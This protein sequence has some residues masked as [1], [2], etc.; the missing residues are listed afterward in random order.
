MRHA[1]YLVFR[2]CGAPAAA[3]HTARPRARDADP[4]SLLDSLLPPTR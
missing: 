1:T 3:C 4:E 2:T